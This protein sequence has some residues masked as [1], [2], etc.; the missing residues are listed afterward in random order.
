MESERKPLLQDI[1]DAFSG[2]ADIFDQASE[3]IA[4]K[5]V[6]PLKRKGSPD[7]WLMW[8]LLLLPDDE[9]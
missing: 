2:I 6:P 1:Q 9:G 3:E 4:P 7:D 8:G 5:Y